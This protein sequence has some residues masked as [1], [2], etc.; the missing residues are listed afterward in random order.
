MLKIGIRMPPFSI[1]LPLYPDTTLNY[2]FF[3]FKMWRKLKIVTVMLRG[4]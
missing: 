3:W 2:L 1:Y 4:R